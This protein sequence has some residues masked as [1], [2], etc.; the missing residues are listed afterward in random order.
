MAALYVDEIA[1]QLVTSQRESPETQ[2]RQKNRE[3][4]ILGQMGLHPKPESKRG[5][6]LKPGY[7]IE[8]DV[9]VLLGKLRGEQGFETLG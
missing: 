5:T 8:E 9:E 4:S 2:R 3:V 7:E 1:V 6:S